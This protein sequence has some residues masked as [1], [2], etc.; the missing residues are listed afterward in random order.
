M[1]SGMRIGH[2]KTEKKRLKPPPDYSSRAMQW[3]LLAAVGGL[4]L[5]VV[6]AGEVRN[7]ERWKWLTELSEKASQPVED[8][9]PRLT[10]ASPPASDEVIINDRTRPKVKESLQANEFVSSHDRAWASGWE[11]VFGKLSNPDRQ[12]IYELLKAAREQ[13]LF[14]ESQ[15]EPATEAIQH[16]DAYWADYRAAAKTEMQELSDEEKSA[17]QPVLEQL[18]LRWTVEFKPLLLIVAQGQELSEAQQT[19]L[20]ALQDLLDMLEL[21][22]VQDNTPTRNSEREIW[23]RLLGKLQKR[24]AEELRRSSAGPISYA[25]LFKQ[26]ASYR[27]KLTTVRGT[28]ADVYWVQAPANAYGI[29]RYWVYWLRPEG[30]ANSPILVYAL[31]KPKGFPSVDASELGHKKMPSLEDVEFTGFFFKRYAYQGQGGIYTAPMLLA[32]EPVWIQ[33]GFGSRMELPSPVTFLAVVAGLA[34]LATGL[35]VW[36]YYQYRPGRIREID[37]PQTVFP[38]SAHDENPV[39]TQP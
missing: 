12:Q 2:R 28:A 1:E 21:K 35:A 9:N 14:R 23:F 36:V 24:T 15:V 3:R 17:W 37:L 34:V 30:G 29:K 33:S 25:Q 18:E 31:D 19:Q 5:I 26:S 38:N 4:M 27:G 20:A 10:E 11:D 22:A 16:L 6:L 7:P 8:I 13:E 39:E 32:R